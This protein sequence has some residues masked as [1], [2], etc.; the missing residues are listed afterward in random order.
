[1][2]DDNKNIIKSFSSYTGAFKYL[3]L[4]HSGCIKKQIDK[5]KKA[6]GYY[7]SNN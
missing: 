4:K 7:W 3:K 6:Y 5:G 1:M 2:L